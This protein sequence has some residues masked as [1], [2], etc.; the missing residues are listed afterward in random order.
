MKTEVVGTEVSLRLPAQL[1]LPLSFLYVNKEESLSWTGC[2]SSSASL[3]GTNSAA[4]SDCRN[5][6]LIPLFTDDYC[7]NV[8]VAVIGKK[9][10]ERKEK[11]KERGSK[12]EREYK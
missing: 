3:Y 6:C 1:T 7:D 5:L 9:E 4:V 2:A 8:S 12:K 11:G 10:R